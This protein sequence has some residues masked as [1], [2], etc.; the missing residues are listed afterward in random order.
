MTGCRVQGVPI[1]PTLRL[2]ASLLVLF[3][4]AVPASGQ[5]TI[6]QSGRY[7]SGTEVAAPAAGVSFKIPEAMQ[8]HMDAEA[9]LFLLGS[10]GVQ[11]AV[12][13]YSEGS[14]DDLADVIGTDLSDLEVILTEDRVERDGTGI[15]GWYDALSGD[16]IGRLFGAIRSGPNGAILGAAALGPTGSDVELESVV[17]AIFASVRWPEPEAREW[18]ASL[19]GTVLTGGGGHSDF[20]PDYTGNHL[21]QAGQEYT[22]ITLCRDGSYGFESESSV[23]VSTPEFSV[24]SAGEDAHSGGWSLV[25]DIAG[26]ALLVLTPWDRDEV[27]YDLVP[28][29][30]GVL[31]EGY[32]YGVEAGPC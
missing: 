30:G 13:A 16:G 29:E 6:Q 11:A 25:G 17:Q 4:L 22:E 7:E 15:Q 24:S 32:A 19:A 23:S 12:W 1:A 27:F 14:P 31:L 2:L 5:T 8:G 20:N 3:L 9:E 26:N 28:V 18:Q 10:D 21:S